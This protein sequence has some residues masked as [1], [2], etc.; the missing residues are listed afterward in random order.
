MAERLSGKTSIVEDPKSVAY[1]SEMK[2]YRDWLVQA[3]KKTLEA[4]DKAVMT[5]SGG[6]LAIS[7]TFIKDVVPSPKAGTVNLLI[8]AWILLTGSIGAILVSIIMSHWALRK[9]I[10]QVDKA[11]IYTGRAGGMFSWVTEILNVVAGT[12]FVVGVVFLAR[13][14]VANMASVR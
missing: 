1:S 12:A 10:T 9:A 11:T 13:F 8:W 7:L 2:L 14:A 5:L 6:A 4:Y 3:D